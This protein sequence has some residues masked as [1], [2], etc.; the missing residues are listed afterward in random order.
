MSS[1]AT[2]RQGGASLASVNYVD[3]G[4]GVVSISLNRSD[5][6]NAFDFEMLAALRQALR[7]FDDDQAANVAVLSGEGRAFCSGVDVKAL[8]EIRR[9]GDAGQLAAMQSVRQLLFECNNWK[10]VFVAA[11]GYV[12]GMALEL[13][14]QADMV[15]AVESTQFQVSETKVGVSTGPIWPIVQ[16]HA[17]A[18][19]ASEVCLTG[20]YFGARE[21]LNHNLIAD[22]AIDKTE[23]VSK[24]VERAKEV[25]RMPA[26]SIRYSVRV[27]RWYIQ[28]NQAAATPFLES[29]FRLLPGAGL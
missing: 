6:L 14:F 11:H 1:V 7:K 17:G 12:M 18:A 3:V 8:A 4:E 26:Q 19:F 23:C 22:V 10:P 27:A 29:G 5:R 28:S 24:V 2:D 9:R 20:R 21:A 13:V 25:S 15:I 16:Y